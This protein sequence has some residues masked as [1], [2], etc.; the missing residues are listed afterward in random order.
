[1]WDNFIDKL[2]DRGASVLL[3]LALGALV[4]GLIAWWRR[5]RERSRILLGDARDTVVIEQHI[6]EK[7]DG[8][9]GNPVRTLRIRSLG[10][11]ELQHVV[12]NSHLAGEF[13]HRAFRV[14][15]RDTLISM[16]G[17]EGSYLLETLTNFVCDRVANE[18]FEHDLFVMAPCCEPAEL[19]QYQ[20]IVVLLISAADLTLFEEWSSCRDFLV[21]HG[22]DGARILT[23]MEMARRYKKEQAELER[24][25]T[26]GQR[27]RHVETMYI[28]DL[29]LDTRAAP[30]PAKKVPWGRF[31]TVL[32]QLN[33]E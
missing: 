2:H 13:S 28:L 22:A 9:D 32:K 19:A 24:L 29:A 27:T 4:T 20:P 21:E 17:A 5:R 16:A 6:I 7:V 18:P 15:S 10:Q 1:M 11:G 26:A 30:V 31:E 14:T 33:L 25:R 23:L 8:A 3:G 12:P